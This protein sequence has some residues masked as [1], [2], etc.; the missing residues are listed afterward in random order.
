LSVWRPVAIQPVA[1]SQIGC[2]MRENGRPR[3]ST[4][5]SVH[6][7]MRRTRSSKSF[8]MSSKLRASGNVCSFAMGGASLL[9][10]AEERKGTR[11]ARLASMRPPGCWPALL[12][13]FLAAPALAQPDRGAFPLE[14][15]LQLIVLPR[16]LIAIDGRTGG[17]REEALDLGEQVL[18][19]RADGRVGIALTDRRILAIATS[20]GSFQE[21]RFARGEALATE[22]ELG[23]RVALFVTN[24]R[25]I[26]FDGG[27]GNLV[28][29]RLGP[30]EFVIG[31]AIANSVAIAATSRRA[32][33]LSPFRGGFFEVRL[34]LDER[35]TSLTASGD[36]AT[37]ATEDRIL[38]FRAASGSWE[39]RTLGLGH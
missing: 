10:R 36:V 34:G 8:A 14:D 9:R 27:S 16:S 33:G 13:L 2:R 15:R 7:T 28:E 32:L 1:P 38:T 25:L 22:P 31:T 18:S 29:T 30:R 35:R 26:G 4:V 5:V 20:S 24:R 39:E 37:L 12:A 19:Q 17:Q 23:D 11:V 6:Q 21:A 3:V